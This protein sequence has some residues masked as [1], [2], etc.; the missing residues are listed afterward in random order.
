MESEEL[1]NGMPLRVER[2]I[3]LVFHDYVN[4]RGLD[5]FRRDILVRLV[6][7]DIGL[8]WFKQKLT[9]RIFEDIQPLTEDEW[10]ELVDNEGKSVKTERLFEL[11]LI[12]AN[13]YRLKNIEKTEEVIK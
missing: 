5:R 7:K 11:N 9:K 3:D 12:I 13:L 10:N 2:L 8:S 6:R 1:G 4:E